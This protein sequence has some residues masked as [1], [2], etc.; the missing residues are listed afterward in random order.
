MIIDQLPE[1]SNTQ[2]TDEI[3]IERGT[4]TYK[5]KVSTFFQGL[6]D[7]ITNGLALKVAKAGDTM[8]GYL[9][10]N[11]NTPGLYLKSASR[12]DGVAPS[13]TGNSIGYR[14][15]DKNNANIAVVTDF[16][17]SDGRQGLWLS[18]WRNGVNNS[19]H[20]LVNSSG[21]RVVSLGAPEAWRSALGLGTSGE[22]PITIGQGGTGHTAVQAYNTISDIA[23]AGTNI[24][25]TSAGMSVWGKVAMLSLTVKANAAIASGDVVATIVAGKRPHRGTYCFDSSSGRVGINTNGQIII[26]HAI[27]SG[28]SVTI[29]AIY[30]LSN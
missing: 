9:T 4:T 10:I 21:Q 11:Q 16:W 25:I 15:R 8:T 1:I 29:N 26:T 22:L 12:E 7:A 17:G 18:G 3:P 5:T 27:A 14:L 24:S 28:G 2:D 20:L 23:T 19:I 13:S 6:R 30:L